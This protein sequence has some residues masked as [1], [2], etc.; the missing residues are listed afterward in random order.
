MLHLDSEVLSRVWQNF[1]DTLE[2][3]VTVEYLLNFS[4]APLE[5]RGAMLSVAL[6]NLT[7]FLRKKHKIKSK[8]PLEKLAWKELKKGLES[9]ID[10]FFMRSLISKLQ[11][12]VKD[13]SSDWN[14]D[15][16]NIFKTRIENLNSPTNLA[17]LTKPFEW[18]GITLSKEEIE[19]IR[20]RNKF[21]HEGK[22][23]DPTARQDSISWREVNA[24]EMRIFTLINKLLL[25]YLQY[26]GPLIDWSPGPLAN[27]R[28]F[29]YLSRV[30]T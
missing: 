14:E 11:N 4:F 27:Q 9:I 29:L 6:E 22:I 20:M 3:A 26:E 15:A 10:Q 17:K 30:A 19:A 21:L 25:S 18:F 12:Y 5:M 28:K 8:G 2:L 24:V 16:K 13:N 7:D 23:L 1:K